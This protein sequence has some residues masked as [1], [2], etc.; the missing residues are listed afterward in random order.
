MSR[1]S[2]QQIA[3]GIYNFEAGREALHAAQETLRAC[4]VMGTKAQIEAD[5]FLAGLIEKRY[6]VKAAPAAKNGKLS[7]LA[8]ES[9][10]KAQK[11]Q[12][13][14]R[15]WITGKAQ[16]RIAAAISARE[17]RNEMSA[18]EKAMDSIKTKFAALEK[19][20]KKEKVSKAELRA[21]KQH[22]KHVL[23]MVNGRLGV[24]E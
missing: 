9:G 21:I 13:R 10:S 16:Q 1:M 17:T 19:I 24:A 11:F 20:A 5:K 3:Q 4:A 7:G 15:E 22:A 2:T 8:F 14:C 12:S 18:D 6:S 23:S